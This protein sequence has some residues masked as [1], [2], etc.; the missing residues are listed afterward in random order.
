MQSDN[1]ILSDIFLQ[2]PLVTNDLFFI[3]FWY[4]IIFFL[5]QNGQLDIIRSFMTSRFDTSGIYE[6]T[7]IEF[8][9]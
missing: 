6:T 4:Q 3:L 8:V 1:L 9:I 2:F 5:M 7:A